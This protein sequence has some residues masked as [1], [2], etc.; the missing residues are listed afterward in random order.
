MRTSE[1]RYEIVSFA[2]TPSIRRRL[3][4]EAA[5]SGTD[6]S[7]FVH[8]EMMAALRAR[9]SAAPVQAHRGAGVNTN[10]RA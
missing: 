9:A 8:G 10:A 7:I 5:R 6:L 2:V 1:R 3:E 4:R